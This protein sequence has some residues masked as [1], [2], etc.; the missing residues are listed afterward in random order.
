MNW[1]ESIT[2]VLDKSKEGLAVIAPIAILM[3]LLDI[4]IWISYPSVEKTPII[5]LIVFTLMDIY[6]RWI[7]KVLK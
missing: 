4:Y 7:K 1:K 5:I 6:Y 3:C 2:L